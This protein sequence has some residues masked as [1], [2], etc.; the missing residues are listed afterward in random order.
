MDLTKHLTTRADD[1]HAT[2]VTWL[3]RALSP[4]GEIPRMSNL[5][6][7]L[8]LPSNST[9]RST[10]CAGPR[11]F[12]YVLVLRPYSTGGMLHALASLLEGSILLTASIHSLRRGLP[13]YLIPFAPHA[14]VP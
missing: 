14:F 13:G 1:G 10:A 8:R 6:K 7:V 5:G 4:F 12:L 2:P 3:P 11:Q 9:T